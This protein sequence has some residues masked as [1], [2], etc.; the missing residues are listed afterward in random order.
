[1]SGS[2]N[3]LAKPVRRRIRRL[4]AFLLLAFLLPPLLAVATHVLRGEAHGRWYEARRDPTH[5][6]PDPAETREAVVQAYAARAFG[7]RGALGVHSWIAWKD[8][9]ADHWRRIEVTGWSVRRGGGDAVRLSRGNPDGYW[10]GSWPVLLGEARGAAAEAA[11]ARIEARAAAYPHRG[12][13]RLWPGPNSNTFIAYMLRGLPELR[14]D[15]PPT[16]IGKDYLPEG[17]FWASAPSGTGYQVSAGGLAGV[18]LAGEEGLEINIL[19]FTLGLDL[20][21]PAV[22]LPGVGR[23]GWPEH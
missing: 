5:Q 10:F 7:W 13:Y 15:L 23:V 3:R 19:G 21:P 2:K 12:E 14:A 6:A 20:S 1:M 9:G 4:A 11:I 17:A 8:T 22:K 18:M 16:A